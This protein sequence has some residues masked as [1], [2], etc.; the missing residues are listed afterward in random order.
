[1]L[2]RIVWFCNVMA[3]FAVEDKPLRKIMS[4]N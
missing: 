3:G 4:R 2:L 1:M